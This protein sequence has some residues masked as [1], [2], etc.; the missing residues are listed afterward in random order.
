LVTITNYI[1]TAVF[2]LPHTDEEVFT[3]IDRARREMAETI[4]WLKSLVTITNYIYTAVFHLPHT[5]EEV[6]TNIDTA[7]REM[8]ETIACTCMSLITS[9]L[10]MTENNNYYCRNL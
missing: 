7:R 3:N 8:A 9:R 6:Y 2:H 1:Y 5:D 4:A 10:Y